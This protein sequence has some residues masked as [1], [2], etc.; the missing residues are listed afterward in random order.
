MFNKKTIDIAVLGAG[1]AGL[2]AAHTLADKGVDFV[3]IDREE[4]T[5]THSYALALHP[6]TLE[7]LNRL[8]IIDPVLEQATRL[9]RAALFD[10]SQKQRAVIDYSQLP[11]KY[12][13]LAIIAQ[14]ELEN[15]LVKAL[16]KKGHKPMWRHRARCITQSSDGVAFTVDRLTDGVTG[17]AMA[18]METE[19]DKI[20]EY[21]AN[22]LIAAD[23]FESQARKS[24][25][26]SFPEIG[27]SL[28]YAVFEFETNTRLLSEMRMMI[29]G[30]RT[31]LYWPL[32]DGR[33][34]FSF[35]ME[36]GFAERGSFNKSHQLV[37][38]EAQ[39]AP[40]LSDHHLNTLL[41]L[42]APWF[43]GS[44]KDVKW[45][46][47]VHFERRLADHFGKDRIWL[48]GDA[49][50]MAAPAGMLSM[51]VGMHEAADLATRLG[52]G[53]S[54]DARLFSLNAYTQNCSSEWRRLL[55]MDFRIVGDGI[56]A[57]WLLQH[58]NN[59]IG[60]LPV[61]GESFHSVLKQL[62]LAK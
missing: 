2:I 18:H 54:D 23:G 34:R 62:H 44:T 1:P 55:D 12:P 8:N 50:H 13:F 41:K 58:R 17:Y 29:E 26:I 59:V 36:P 43:I 45:R 56:G 31:H 6:E 48:A 51:N 32:G 30:D 28:D 4:R 22:Y 49:A 24:A 53:T 5:N 57:E 11:V 7:L 27:P 14:N 37:D 38:R 39:N 15:I 33:C 9:Q 3:L 25:G 52:A 47:V 42:H 16:K 20:F 61:S 60:N 46:A 40:E 21:K 19:I 35:Q 10:E